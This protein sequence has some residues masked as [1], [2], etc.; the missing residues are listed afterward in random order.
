MGQTVAGRFVTD[1]RVRWSDLDAFGHVNN[2]RTITL[3][4]EARVDWLFVE[5]TD[6][7]VD[8]LT[9]GIV[10]SQL[11][12]RYRR[13]IPFG[14]QVTVSMGVLKLG[15]SAFTI[16]Y[17]VTVDGLLSATASTVLVPV[18]SDTFRPRRLDQGEREFLTDY[19]S[20]VDQ[21][22]GNGG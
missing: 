7:G 8:R 15:G 6:R 16:D 1:V 5:A 14:A 18:N 2:A 20:T 19:L 13:P 4:E 9:E 12:I 10:V 22:T 11:E 17:L 3:L 21:S